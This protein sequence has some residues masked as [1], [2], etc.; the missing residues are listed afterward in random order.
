M[1]LFPYCLIPRVGG[2]AWTRVLQLGCALA[3]LGAAA[4]ARSMAQSATPA[5]LMSYQGYLVD[6][7]G[8][9]LAN[10]NP[11]NYTIVFRL[12]ATSSGGSSL[13]AE[14]QTVTVDKG[15]FAVVLG[16]GVQEGSE[17]RPALSSLFASTSA[18]DRYIGI[19]VK[20]LSGGD[21]EIMPRLRLLPSP[22]AFLA[23]SANG[24]VAADGT[25]L[26]VPDA[27]R[28][29]LSQA[30]Q[31]TGGNA[32]GESAV[33]LQVS[34]RPAQPTQVASGRASTLT[35]GENNTA[36]GETSVVAGGVG[37]TAS[38]LGSVALGGTANTASGAHATTV[39]GRQNTASGEFSMA[40]G[41]RA[42][43]IHSGTFVWADGQDADFAS[44]AANQFNIRASGGVG[45]NT[46][47]EAGVGLKVAGRVKADT[48]D[49]TTLNVGTLSATTLSGYG[50]TPIGGII[51]W[52]G[53]D[54]SIPA[55]WALCN[56]QTI[57]NRVTP[58]LRDRFI[59]GASGTR[60]TGTTGGSASMNLTANQLPGH[61]HTVSGSVDSQGGHRHTPYAPPNSENG[62]GSQGYPAGNNHQAFRS[63]DRGRSYALNVEAL[64]WE[65]THSHSFNVTS[66][67]TGQ[68]TAIDKMPPFYALAFI[69]RVQ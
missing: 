58:D 34:R 67:S 46:T 17:P 52:S 12:Y 50:T 31:S 35:G 53:S 9:P 18:S 13:W 21:P 38:G 6:A 15:S 5:D 28:L 32:R 63:S 30:I 4:P 24:L 11:V 19:T 23:R 69:M 45:V 33:D 27:G 25:S 37:N 59:I 1:N 61:S 10:S 14:S 42:N 65:G 8:A 64:S 54:A 41:R 62:A 44:T 22:Y 51:M 29:R 16:E 2:A 66:G 39:G 49:V 7:N 68:G 43:A 26:L 56:G 47:A 40:A 55:G 36:S 20:G 57:N 48:V 60:P 3:I